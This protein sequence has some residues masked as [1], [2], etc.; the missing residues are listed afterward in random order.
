MLP[1][2][3]KCSEVPGGRLRAGA[4]LGWTAPG[5]RAAGGPEGLPHRA[6]RLRDP[7]GRR[8]GCAGGRAAGDR[9]A[10]VAAAPVPGAGL[11]PRARQPGGR[12]APWPG[13]DRAT[14]GVLASA[15][16]GRATPVV[17]VDPAVWPRGA[18]E[19]SPGRGFYYHPSR[20]SAGQP[21]VAGWCQ[22][23][24]V[25]LGLAP[26]SWTAPVDVG[27]LAPDDNLNRVAAVVGA[28]ASAPTPHGRSPGRPSGTRRG[29][30]PRYPAI[31]L[32]A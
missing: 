28:P 21:I 11:S 7:P 6:I 13:A 15:A 27:R 24:I 14:A 2:T 30:A 9:A 8:A 26:N 4:P 3:T 1:S 31:N 16:S 23:L 17:A 19:C 18:A 12:P 22:P 20:P 25:G 10:G 32:T 29:P 5:F